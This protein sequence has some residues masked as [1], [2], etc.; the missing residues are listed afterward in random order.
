MRHNLRTSRQNT[1][2]LALKTHLQLSFLHAPAAFASQLT[3]IS[4]KYFKPCSK[5]TPAIEIPARPSVALHAWSPVIELSTVHDLNVCV[6]VCVY[7]VRLCVC[8]CF[9]CVRVCV[10][11]LYVFVRM[12]MCMCVCTCTCMCAGRLCVLCVVCAC[13]QYILY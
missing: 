9:K 11:I 3:H 8:A 6:F 2:N 12:C 1:P 13:K 7:C 10:C 5:N 4:S